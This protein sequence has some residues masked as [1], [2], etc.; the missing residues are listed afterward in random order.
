MGTKLYGVLYWDRVSVETDGVE[1]MV[2]VT[3]INNL[4]V[5]ELQATVTYISTEI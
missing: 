1:F 5:E 2:T 4:D 3:N